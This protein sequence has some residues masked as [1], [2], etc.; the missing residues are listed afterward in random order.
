MLHSLMSSVEFCNGECI[1]ISEV[2]F[3]GAFVLGCSFTVFNRFDSSLMYA[4]VLYACPRGHM[5]GDDNT[6]RHIRR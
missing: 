4:R 1:Y 6:H 2:P 3:L 5:S